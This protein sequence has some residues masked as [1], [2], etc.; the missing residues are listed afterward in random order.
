MTGVGRYGPA[1]LKK[2][3]K[4]QEILG[5][6]FHDITWLREGL[7]ISRPIGHIHAR[8]KR[9]AL[10]GDHKIAAIFIDRW[11]SKSGLRS[12]DWSEIYSSNFS[13]QRFTDITFRHG[14]SDCTI[15]HAMMRLP[16]NNITDNTVR[17]MSDTLEALLG[18]IYKDA[19]ASNHPDPYGAVEKAAI[20]LGLADRR[21]LTAE[22]LRWSVE[23]L[24]TQRKLPPRMFTGHHFALA[25]TLH[26]LD[27]PAPPRSAALQIHNLLY[28]RILARLEAARSDQNSLSAKTHQAL[29]A[30]TQQT[31]HRLH[32]LGLGLRN[33]RASP[34]LRP[35]SWQWLANLRLWVQTAA[36]AFVDPFVVVYASIQTA[37]TPLIP[38]LMPKRRP[39]KTSQYMKYRLRKGSHS[40]FTRRVLEGIYYVLKP[41]SRAWSKTKLNIRRWRTKPALII[42]DANNKMR[43]MQ[44]AVT[45]R[46]QAIRSRTT[47]G[48][49]ETRASIA[50]RVTTA[51]EK[52][53]AVVKPMVDR[54]VTA[55]KKSTTAVR[56]FIQHHKRKTKQSVTQLKAV[57]TRYRR[58]TNHEVRVFRYRTT[59]RVKRLFRLGP[60]IPRYKKAIRT[61]VGRFRKRTTNRLQRLF[62]IKA[63][64]A[65]YKAGFSK[66]MGNVF[67]KRPK[68]ASAPAPVQAVTEAHSQQVIVKDFENGARPPVMSAKPLEKTKKKPESVA[69]PSLVPGQTLRLEE[70]K[71]IVEAM[72]PRDDQSMPETLHDTTEQTK[73]QEEKGEVGREERG[74]G[75]LVSAADA[76]LLLPGQ[77]AKAQQDERF[78]KAQ[79]LLEQEAEESR[80]SEARVRLEE[81]TRKIQEQ[82]VQ[83]LQKQAAESL[84]ELEAK[85][86]EEEEAQKLQLQVQEDMRQG[87]QGASAVQEEQTSDATKEEVVS[88]KKSKAVGKAA[89]KR[90]KKRLAAK[91]AAERKAERK[92]EKTAKRL[93]RRQGILTAEE[94][95]RLR[96]KVLRSAERLR[97]LN[98]GAQLLAYQQDE[99][100]E[101][102]EEKLRLFEAGA[103]AAAEDS[104]PAREDEMEQGEE[105]GRQSESAEVRLAQTEKEGNPQRAQSAKSVQEDFNTVA[106]AKEQELQQ[107]DDRALRSV[108]DTILHITS[109]EASAALDSQVMRLGYETSPPH[110][111]SSPAERSGDT[112]ISAGQTSDIPPDES[113][114]HS[115]VQQP[116][117]LG[118]H[119]VKSLIQ[120]RAA[121]VRAK[122]SSMDQE[123]SRTMV[124]AAMELELKFLR[125][126]EQSHDHRR[127]RKAG[128]S[129][130]KAAATEQTPEEKIKE[131]AVRVRNL[132][133]SER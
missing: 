70:S 121:A 68:V 130:V 79:Q 128:E 69:S 49:L 10:V 105:E 42:P 54:F 97:A 99:E 85:R 36:R 50:N 112:E 26:E 58:A 43:N 21:L 53:R 7:D 110:T 81:R 5:Y 116:I 30:M 45:D 109:T 12:V 56:H 111:P 125:Q 107:L 106:Q 61:A 113:R 117:V 126:S 89:A 20:R 96:L 80:K 83:Q 27:R 24:R 47:N 72:K 57:V 60:A 102:F 34:L 4:A 115:T 131:L 35:K 51:Q 87:E 101:E 46:L 93:R 90:E 39:L 65:R 127:A 88:V 91:R 25:S 15:P 29:L 119:L 38:S 40:R 3:V 73:V 13:N 77:Q 92:A 123:T 74:Q 63:A 120:Q 122:D 103:E 59:K 133:M 86:L 94:E 84:H 32:D 11:Y 100:I 71:Q 37:F 41:C 82:V 95:E 23:N 9:L 17:I 31:G 48:I 28:S 67:Q 118:Q 14:L 129:M 62:A 78:A 8:N 108:D 16:G 76:T 22:E 66:R 44:C 114:T 1:N 6:E 19:V 75:D 52:S 104:K 64:I 33:L 55:R 2:L 124:Q 98:E 18:A 132:I